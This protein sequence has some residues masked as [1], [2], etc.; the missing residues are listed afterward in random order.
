MHLN[1]FKYKIPFKGSFKTSNNNFYS[2]KGVIIQLKKEGITARGEASP[3]PGFSSE[4][5][6]E[7]I[8]QIQQKRPEIS[9]FLSSDFNHSDLEKFLKQS[10]FVHSLRFGLFTLVTFY[11]AQKKRENLSLLLFNSAAASVKVNAVIDM[12]KRSLL[13][14]ARQFV[15]RGFETIKIKA[16]DNWD[17]L[18]PQIQK[19]REEYK[20]INIRLDANR[21]WR[22]DLAIDCLKQAE[23]LEIEY[24]EEPLNNITAKKLQQLKKKTSVSIAIDEAI[25]HWPA[26]KELALAADVFIIKPMLIGSYN[27]I[28]EICQFA[29]NNSKRVIFTSTLGTANERLATAA[30]ASG[31]GSN[32]QAHGLNTGH[33]LTNDA[34]DDSTFF[35]KNFYELPDYKRLNQ[36][37]QTDLSNLN[38]VSV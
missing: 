20:D 35:V 34:W 24:C 7:L 18:F 36:L 25:I 22:L 31:F 19:I 14:Q 27:Q 8:E 10:G 12:K 9:N 21:R 3:L 26:V 5:L 15:N 2:R 1:F 30:L 23:E 32:K 28:K 38:L 4:K 16:G 33:L 11:L 37:M 29:R 13:P 17:A 6:D